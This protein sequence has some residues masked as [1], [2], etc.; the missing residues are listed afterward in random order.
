MYFEA[1]TDVYCGS[2]TGDDCDCV[3]DVR[4]SGVCDDR[5]V[6][7]PVFV[8]SQRTSALRDTGCSA[9]INVDEHL[10]RSIL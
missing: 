10:S 5:D 3:N 2:E 7:I 9:T 1:Q 4:F 6:I 8:N